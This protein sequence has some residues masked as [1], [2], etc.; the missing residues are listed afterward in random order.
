MKKYTIQEIF[1][2]QI[3]YKNDGYY[4]MCNDVFFWGAADLEEIT[5]EFLPVFDRAVEDCGGEI[6]FGALLYCARQ[7]RMRPQGA[8][9]SFIPKDKWELFNACGPERE[10]G[11]GNPC[12]PGEYNTKKC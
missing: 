3:A 7:R 9:Y 4:I 1:D 5:E 11:F 10:V 12:A 2:E 8:L 6:E